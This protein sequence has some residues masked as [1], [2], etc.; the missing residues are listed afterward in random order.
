MIKKSDFLSM[1]ALFLVLCTSINAW[2]QS[3]CA[4]PTGLTAVV[5]NSASN[6][7]ATVSW[8]PT[9]GATGYT[10]Q[11]VK[12]PSDPNWN[13]ATTV[14]VTDPSH[15]FTNV[16]GT[17]YW[18]VKSE[19]CSDSYYTPGYSFTVQRFTFITLVVN[20]TNNSALLR[21]NDIS[22]AVNYTVQYK[23]ADSP[24]WT[25]VI[26]DTDIITLTGLS[27][28]TSYNW[29]VS[30]NFQAI[31]TTGTPCIYS[32]VYEKGPDFTTQCTL[33][34]AP[35]GRKATVEGTTVAISW[36]PVNGATSYR[37]R[38]FI[39]GDAESLIESVVTGTSI[40]IPNLKTELLYVYL[41]R[42]INDCGESDLSGSS[43]YFKILPA[44]KFLNGFASGATAE[45]RWQ[46]VNS[47]TGYQIQYR[48]KGT[49][50][51]TYATERAN[52]ISASI[53]NLPAGTYEWQMATIHADGISDYAKGNDFV[54]APVFPTNLQVSVSGTTATLSWAPAVNT[55]GYTIQYQRST[56][57]TWSSRSTTATK[58][59][60][61][62][63]TAGSTYYW[64][65]RSIANTIYSSGPLGSLLSRFSYTYN[66]SFHTAS[67]SFCP[68]MASG[69]VISPG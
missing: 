23:P 18:R 10:V 61:S 53:P 63:L 11:L 44:P 56:A 65:V 26:T 59:S 54:V 62:S 15:T 3:A 34:S 14:T 12:T 52:A 37:V 25:T 57:R 7:S 55:K 1:I 17:Y 50:T 67:P 29:Q 46:E 41:V 22:D 64:Q 19:G 35:T 69:S 16:S 32:K 20:T 24:S 43:N 39:S 21:W 68:H 2:G 66:T 51:W 49:T 9:T 42:A 13:S 58:V 47:A 4:V 8:T 27:A 60:L 45:F 28:S 31:T 48:I 5:T 6:N 36:A 33:P 40:V 30:V 38:C